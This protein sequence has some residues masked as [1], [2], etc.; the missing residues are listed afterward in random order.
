MRVHAHGASHMSLEPPRLIRPTLFLI[1][2][3][4]EDAT[5]AE[6]VGQ[7]SG[8]VVRRLEFEHALEPGPRPEPDV[9]VLD[10]D[11][12]KTSLDICRRLAD[13]RVDPPFS[14][15]GITAKG[16][17]EGHRRA[18]WSAGATG[19]L[20]SPLLADELVARVGGLL[21]VHARAKAASA[22]RHWLEQQYEVLRTAIVRAD[23][24][25]SLGML[26]AGVAHEL[27]NLVVALNSAVFGIS[28][29]ASSQWP[30]EHLEDL[31]TLETVGQHVAQHA[32]QMLQF[33]RPNRDETES[34]D[35]PDV[36]NRVA[37]LLRLSGRLRFVSVD[38]Q[39]PEDLPPVSI[40]KVRLEQVLINF[41]ANAADALEGRKDRRIRVS[42]EAEAGRVRIRVEDTGHG[43]APADLERIF[44]PYFT[45]KEPERGTGL[46]LPVVKEIIEKFGGRISVKSTLGEGTVFTVDLPAAAD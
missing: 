14:I 3:G 19:L 4:D 16:F 32:K 2:L 42:A 37:G 25:V 26:S 35:L 33:S 8:W 41:L 34:V 21:A 27:N 12:G 24:F 36:V 13:S 5:T 18:I 30:E 6:L 44:E 45:T 46:G 31:K 15:L 23:Q 28:Q 38:I 40:S 11:R 1:G 20:F 39:M 10:V 43:I 7:V 22:R 29:V 17:D 9:I